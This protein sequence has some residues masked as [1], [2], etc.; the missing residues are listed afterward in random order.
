M[1]DQHPKPRGR[2]AVAGFDVTVTLTKA[3]LDVVT[4]GASLL[5]QL[6]GKQASRAAW[7]RGFI[8]EMADLPYPSLMT[9]SELRERWPV[10]SP[11]LCAHP[12]TVRITELQRI[13][14]R[15]WEFHVQSLDWSRPLYGKETLSILIEAHGPFSISVQ[16]KK[17]Q[18]K[19]EASKG[20]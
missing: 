13:W 18:A 2:P 6:T 3:A 20:L 14:L 9:G 1:S 8:D 12:I 16:R 5:G 7:L 19:K 10:S 4:E 15:Q 11:L 17:L